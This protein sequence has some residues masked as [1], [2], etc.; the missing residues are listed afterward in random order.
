[1]Q[2]EMTR[3]GPVVPAQD[4]APLL[5]VE[6]AE[7]PRLMREGIVSARHEVGVDEDAGR[8]RLVFRYQDLQVR[9]TCTADGAVVSRV[10]ISTGK[11]VRSPG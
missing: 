2:I 8:F 11:P 6:P 4:L 3:D 5:G 1:M 9:L 10:R 7:L